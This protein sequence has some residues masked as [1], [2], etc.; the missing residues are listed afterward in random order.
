M[1]PGFLVGLGSMLLA[2]SMSAATVMP[3]GGWYGGL[4]GGAGYLQD[5]VFTNFFGYNPNNPQNV[6]VVSGSPLIPYT[7]QNVFWPVPFAPP[8]PTLP[9][10][11]TEIDYKVM[12][13]GGLQIGF[14]CNHFRIEGEG[15][16]SY[17]GINKLIFNNLILN[18]PD[19]TFSL[20]MPIPAIPIFNN[21]VVKS[22]SS[23]PLFIVRG[24]T[25][26]YGGLV[27]GYYEFYV[28]DGDVDIVPYIGAGIGY[29]FIQSTARF[30]YNGVQISQP[31]GLNN[32]IFNNTTEGDSTHMYQGILGVSYFL[33]DFTSVGADLRYLRTGTIK[34]LD[35]H[36]TMT[37]LNLNF[38]Y[39]FDQPN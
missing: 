20:T 21:L 15:I 8:T 3:Q 34:T 7:M 13:N 37:S 4:F 16:Y 30:Y 23:S 22:M 1:K 32:I 6:I 18:Y 33:D 14:R 26:M 9:A 19:N 28:P 11:T 29:S 17:T 36:L 38:N 35:E 5:A 24:N 2:G 25:T 31:L 27:N 10:F 39:S 12:G